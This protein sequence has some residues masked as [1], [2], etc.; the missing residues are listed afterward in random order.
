MDGAKNLDG[1]RSGTG[2]RLSVIA[3]S[4][5]VWFPWTN[6]G[7]HFTLHQVNAQD[8]FFF[9]APAAVSLPAARRCTDR[10]AFTVT[11][12]QMESLLN[13]YLVG[14]EEREER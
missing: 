5:N 9:P 1:V 4:H 8:V 2:C 12:S 11:G 10:C 3:G 14:C 13:K 7:H 6:R